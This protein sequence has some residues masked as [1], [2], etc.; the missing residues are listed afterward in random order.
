MA[1]ALAS[2]GLLEASTEP[3][4]VLMHLLFA[5]NFFPEMTS[6]IRGIYWTLPTEIHYYILFPLLLRWV[7]LE[8]PTR[9]A[10]GAVAFAMGYRTFTL[11]IN[12]EHG[13]WI[14]WTA[15]YPPGASI[16]SPSGSSPRA[17]WPTPGRHPQ[18]SRDARCWA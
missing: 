4:V 17:R 2:W 18:P 9:L 15:A 1:V 8:R 14:T 16:S 6:A 12:N 7:P 13:I 3:Q 10:L 11:W 5:Q